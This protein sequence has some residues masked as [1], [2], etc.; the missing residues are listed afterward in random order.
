MTDCDDIETLSAEWKSEWRRRAGEA[1]RTIRESQ[2]HSAETLSQAIRE[3]A[4]FHMSGATIFRI[5]KNER[6]YLDAWE[7]WVIAQAL[8]VPPVQLL[9]PDLPDGDVQ[10]TPGADPVPA[11]SMLAHWCGD[12]RDGLVAHSREWWVIKNGQPA[13]RVSELEALMLVEQQGKAVGP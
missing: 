9:C 13:R 5:E 11:A 8:D 2:G 12:D 4:N 6:G 7:V 10:P 3:K 1:I